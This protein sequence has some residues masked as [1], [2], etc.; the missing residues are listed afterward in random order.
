MF[1]LSWFLARVHTTTCQGQNAG[2]IPSVLRWGWQ[3]PVLLRGSLARPGAKSRDF[4]SRACPCLGSGPAGEGTLSWG[5]SIWVWLSLGLFTGILILIP[6]GRKALPVPSE[7]WC[8]CTTCFGQWDVSRMG[9]TIMSSHAPYRICSCWLL[10][11]W[12]GNFHQ[13][14][15]QRDNGERCPTWHEQEMLLLFESW[16]FGGLLVTTALLILS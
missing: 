15:S 16:K 10:C 7:V 9:A 11:K 13:F 8:G 14:G 2:C 1:F 3:T 4:Y 5:N 12:R 6:S